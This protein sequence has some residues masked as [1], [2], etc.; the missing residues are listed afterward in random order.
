M[1]ADAQPLDVG[2]FDGLRELEPKDAAHRLADLLASSGSPEAND[3]TDA[4]V[5]GL[6]ADRRMGDA[7]LEHLPLQTLETITARCTARL[8]DEDADLARGSR[9]SAWQLLDVLRRNPVLRRIAETRSTDAWTER[10]QALLESSHFTFGHLLTQRAAGYGERTLF[11]VPVNGVSRTISW[12]QAAGRVDLIARSRLAVTAETGDR[13]VAILSHNSLEMALVDL[14]CLSAGVVNVMVPATATETDVEYILKHAGVGTIFVSD[15]EQLKKVL[16]VRD[17]FPELGPIIAL[18]AS[19]VAHPDTIDFEHLLARSSEVSAAQLADRRD[20]QKISDLATIMYTSGTTGTPKGICFSQLNIVFKRFARAL[21]LPEIGESDRFL[22]YLPLFHTFG[23]FLELTGCVFWGAVY[24]FAESPNIDTLTRQMRELEV[25]VLISIPMKWMQLFDLVR[26]AVDLETA[27]DHEIGAV[28]RRIVGPDLRWGLSAAGYLDP[29]IFLF[30]QRHGVELMSGFGMTEATGGITMTPPGAYQEDSLGLPLPGI[31]TTLAE[32]GELLVRGPYVMRGYLDPPDGVESFDS[33]GWFHTGDLMERGN[34]GFLRIV[35]RKKEIYKNING[36]TI[37]P[38]KIENLFRDFESVGR[39][40][41]VGD[42]REFNTALIYPN[43]DFDDLDFRSLPREDLKTHFRSLVV[44]ANSFLAPYERIVDF[45]VIDRDF[46]ADRGELTAKGTY[47]RK[48]IERAFSDQLRLLYRRRTLSVGGA[49]VIVPN[50]FFQALG[51]TTQELRVED[52]RLILASHGTSLTVSQGDDGEV[53]VGSAYY[54]PIK[55]AIDLGHL[56]ATPR[57][58]MGNG[59]LV[60]FAPLEPGQRDHRR[61]RNL[62]AQ[63]LRRVGTHEATSAELEAVGALL[64]RQEASVLDLHTAALVL[65]AEDASDA[66]TAVQALGHVLDIGDNELTD[67]VLRILRRAVDMQSSL[68]RRRAFQVLASSEKDTFYRQ[69]LASFLDR[70]HELLDSETISV[71]VDR[72][73]SPKQIEAFM[74]EAEG[75]CAKAPDEGDPALDSLAEFLASYGATHPSRYR[76]LRGFFTRSALNAPCEQARELAVKAKKRLAADFRAWLG[77]PSRVAV[78]PE[79]GL[80]YRWEDVVAFSDEVEEEDRIRLLAAIRTTPIIREAS[81]LFG[82]APTVRLE[83]ILP[84]GVWIRLLGS[85]HGKSVFRLAIRTRVRDQLDLAL[86]LNRGLSP[87]AVREEINWLTVCSEARG[88]GPLVEIFGGAWPEHELWTEEFIPGE[89]LDHALSRLARRREDPERLATWWPFAAWA[90][91]G[92]YVDFWNRT[93]RRLVVADP[94]PANV[95]V[96]M[97]DYQIGA[98]LVSIS[99]RKPF[100]SVREM[101]GSFREF[102]INPIEAEH[103]ELTGLAGWDVLFSAILQIAGE[104]DGIAMLRSVLNEA[105]CSLPSKD[106]S[107]RL[108]R[109]GF[110]PA[111]CSSPPNDTVDG[112]ASTRM[113]LEALARGR[114]TRFSSLTESRICERRTQRRGRGSSKKPCFAMD[115][116][117]WRLL[118]KP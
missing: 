45:S 110:S 42:H 19:A 95:I 114:S 96:P 100:T 73:L 108:G 60:D 72:D 52:D 58:W 37:A 10:I 68:V 7:I 117:C 109:G 106:T 25:S 9:E 92:A 5:I 22:C 26:Q 34:D 12:R 36:Q 30:L 32:D 80:E 94:S 14:A 46:E 49:A 56:V 71:L 87:E 64:R 91:V 79:T 107:I 118:W 17:G 48:E 116:R 62:S 78:D 99:S 16:N 13:R 39:I 2:P 35:D 4:A 70:G 24:C 63:W 53:R 102:F 57:L 23:R 111:V 54:R 101:L 105:R 81:F 21:A 31:D 40:F 44:S 3:G 76:Q 18:E 50:W 69:T 115:Q 28:L 27:D 75:R 65:A 43:P 55:R 89:T 15:A 74:D 113:R 112:S 59:E 90:A 29:E 11:R 77:A 85:S 1:T 6:L 66:V 93:G 82:G 103:P 104:D 88:L 41:L 33:D 61:R 86:N 98:R 83:D 97:H 84:G 38:Q 51:I 67:E 47:R 8:A 20:R